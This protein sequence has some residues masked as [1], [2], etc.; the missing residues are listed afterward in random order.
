MTDTAPKR[1]PG[2][3]PQYTDM[4]R[5]AGCEL[6]ADLLARFQAV[7]GSSTRARLQ[8]LLDER[9]A[10]LEQLVKKARVNELLVEDIDRLQCIASHK[11]RLADGTIMVWHCPDDQIPEP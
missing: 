8:A 3:P 1:R 7:P 6:P 5:L 10:L 11:V 2:R 4:R 9:D